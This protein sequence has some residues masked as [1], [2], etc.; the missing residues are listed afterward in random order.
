[1]T[2]LPSEELT[3]ALIDAYFSAENWSFPV[4]DEHHFRNLYQQFRVQLGSQSLPNDLKQLPS[5]LTTFPALV[6]SVLAVILQFSVPE[7]EEARAMNLSTVP[8]CIWLSQRY[9]DTG[10]R[11]IRLFERQKPTTTSIEFHLV[12]MTWLKNCGRGGESWQ[13]LGVALR[14][15]QEIDLHQIQ[16]DTLQDINTDVGDVLSQVWE[17]EHRKRL[18]AR[19]FI[20][21]SHMAVALGRPRGI[22]REDC[23]TSAPLDCEYPHEPSRT[24]PVGTNHN[25]QPPN[26]FSSV[27]FSIALSHKYH[28]LMSMR[29]SRLDLRDY[30]RVTS[31]HDDVE[32]MLMELPL[33][34]RPSF[35]DTSWDRQKPHLPATRQR[36]LTTANIFLLALHR[37]YISTHATSLKAAIEAAFTILRSQK[38][39]FE[40]IPEAQ[41]KLY[42]YSFYTIDA[43]IFLS[44]TILKH[45][46]PDADTNARALQELQQACVRLGCMKERSL[47]AGAGEVVLR[48]CYNAIQVNTPSSIS[49]T[50][51]DFLDDM[52][53]ITNLTT[54][55]LFEELGFSNPDQAINELIARLDEPL[56]TLSHS[57]GTTMPSSNGLIYNGVDVSKIDSSIIDGLQYPS[58]S[59]ENV[60]DSSD[61]DFRAY[62]TNAMYKLDGREQ[63]NLSS[64]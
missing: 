54:T 4:L 6:Y 13:C 1:M 63:R 19:I 58:F 34:L 40:H 38:M 32:C 53:S 36:I 60:S 41:H 55:N 31:L 33:A 43:G 44:S 64:S 48:R 42:G 23:S 59:T 56:P 46:A 57:P 52:P 39:L 26:D 10:Q 15:A 27:I 37:P 7:S 12:R 50:S 20:M 28:D 5:V 51:Y 11:I 21:D 35:P 8:Q 17:L 29:S 16:E 47:I 61:M 9:L 18:W 62:H 45:L 30:T 24:I 49:T 14:Q 22:H 25:R 3:K 2:G